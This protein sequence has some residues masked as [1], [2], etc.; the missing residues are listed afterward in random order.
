MA[1]LKI[2]LK[3]YR[4]FPLLASIEANRF[5]N[6][7]SNS[8]FSKNFPFRVQHRFRDRMQISKK[9]TFNSVVVIKERQSE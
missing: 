8:F 7:A 3:R 4:F 9:S 5:P 2:L 1:I 6:F